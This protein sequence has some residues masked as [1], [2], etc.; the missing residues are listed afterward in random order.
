M[1]NATIKNIRL[2]TEDEMLDEG[3][4]YGQSPAVIELTD[5]TL[6]YP[7]CDP[8]GNGPGFLFGKDKSGQCFYIYPEEK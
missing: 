4:E 3:W 6:I 8:E 1:L 5:G 2:M 7:S